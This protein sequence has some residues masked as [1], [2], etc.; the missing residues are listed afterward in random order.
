MEIKTLK[1]LMVYG[2]GFTLSGKRSK[3]FPYPMFREVDLKQEAIKDIKAI[4]SG[5]F[6]FM[7]NCKN[8][9]ASQVFAICEYLKWKF[10]ITEEDLKNG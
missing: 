8:I 6:K 2:S 3:R 1:D 9:V 10:N 4:R 5:Y 7:E